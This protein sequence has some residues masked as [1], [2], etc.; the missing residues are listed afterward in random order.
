MSLRAPRPTTASRR[1]RQRRRGLHAGGLALAAG[2]VA[3][4]VG[5]PAQ[6]SGAA[7]ADGAQVTTI[8][9]SAPAPYTPHAPTGGTDDYHC[10]LV[11]PHVAHNSFIVSS[12]FS[13]GQP[14][15]A[16]PLSAAVNCA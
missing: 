11:N 7:T 12:Q 3:T 16:L 13:P 4:L 1:A 2:L 9:M 14:D 10:T 15:K 8:S 6:A 5:V